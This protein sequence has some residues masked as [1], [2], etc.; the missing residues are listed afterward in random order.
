[1]SRERERRGT[2]PGGGGGGKEHR[3]SC[4]RLTK[5]FKS[6]EIIILV[7]NVDIFCLKTTTLPFHITF[8]ECGP[9][10]K[11]QFDAQRSLTGMK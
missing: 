6:D 4:L 2:D 1:M 7:T 10:S 5:D 11:S 3:G 9:R 8:M